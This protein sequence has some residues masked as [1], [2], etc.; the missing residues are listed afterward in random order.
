MFKI[1]KIVE[2]RWKKKNSNEKNINKNIK[3]LGFKKLIAKECNK[4]FNVTLNFDKLMR[5]ACPFVEN[6]PREIVF[7]PLVLPVMS[8][9]SNE[10]PN[11]AREAG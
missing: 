8:Q 2:C 5:E 9:P 6:N 11:A 10:S 3:S 7:F 4:M 1:S